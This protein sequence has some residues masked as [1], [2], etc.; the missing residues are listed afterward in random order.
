MKTRPM[1]LY[2][3]ALCDGFLA[4]WNSTR[5]S[6]FR[7]LYERPERLRGTDENHDFDC[8]DDE[9]RKMLAV[10][11]VRL[12]STDSPVLAV[13]QRRLGDWTKSKDRILS[14][15][16]ILPVDAEYHLELPAFPP[17]TNQ[18][19]RKA[20]EQKSVELIEYL[21]TEAR[22]GKSP[23]RVEAPWGEQ[24][25]LVRESNGGSTRISVGPPVASGPVRTTPVDQFIAKV[26]PD[27]NK[28]LERANALGKQTVLI[29]DL[30][31]IFGAPEYMNR[32]SHNP[33]STV[34]NQSCPNIDTI[35]FHKP[36]QPREGPEYTC[37]YL[38]QTV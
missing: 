9:I 6:S 34:N 3:E 7:R 22:K 35:W 32:L 4:V 33:W 19:D 1:S 31:F 18:K 20:Y 14:Q 37:L 38:V 12:V 8:R 17:E 23:V 28:Q 15:L 16:S 25:V 26:L 24:I 5:G 13:N 29:I 21:L 36:W 2:E 27:K 11:C 10:E 30:D